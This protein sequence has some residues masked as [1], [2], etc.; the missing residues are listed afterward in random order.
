MLCVSRETDEIIT[1]VVG[2][3]SDYFFENSRCYN[4]HLDKA[5][6]RVFFE[7]T[8]FGVFFDVLKIS[9]CYKMHLG[10]VTTST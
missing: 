8:I 5:I 2:Y 10:A 7:N 6:W 3:N 4:I 1:V 9:R